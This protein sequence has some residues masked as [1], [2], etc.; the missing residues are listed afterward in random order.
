MEVGA[1]AEVFAAHVQ[2]MLPDCAVLSEVMPHMSGSACAERM[3]GCPKSTAGR[4]GTCFLVPILQCQTIM[5]T[6]CLLHSAG[7]LCCLSDVL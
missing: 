1:A 4:G 5:H 3:Q 7:V 6:S 2:Q